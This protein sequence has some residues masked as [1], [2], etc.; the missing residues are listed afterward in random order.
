[1]EEIELALDSLESIGVDFVKMYD[2]NLTKEMIY[3]IIKAA[4]KR[5]LKTTGHL[6]FSAD[7][8]MDQN[9]CFMY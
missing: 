3:S 7:M 8:L 5:G 4:E 6:P 2:G 9:I 1:M